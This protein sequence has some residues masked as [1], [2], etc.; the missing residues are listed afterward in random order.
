MTKKKK[1][2]IIIAIAVLI[3]GVSAFFIFNKDKNQSETGAK[4]V[5]KKISKP[6]N[7]IPVSERPF[8]QLIPSPTGHHITIN[9]LELKKTSSNLEYEMEYQTGSMLQGF[10]GILNLAKLP[11]ADKK[12]FGSQSAGGAITYHEDIKGGNLLAEFDGADAY[13]V[14][15]AWNY[16]TNSEE[17]TEFSSQDKLFSISNASLSNYSYIVIYNSPGFPG[18]LET[19][20]VSDVYTLTAEKSLKTISST[21]SVSFMTDNETAVIMG[22][23]GEAWVE[24]ETT[25]AAGVASGSD[26]LMEA[27]LLIAN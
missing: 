18:K 19:E 25:I 6:V 20:P 15:S 11:A 24:I 16:V 13:A 10:Q 17:K 3:L 21:F 23:N 14:K 5:K 12:L 26:A 22:Y 27:Y 1:T 4:V 8:I 7:I 9:V 2:I